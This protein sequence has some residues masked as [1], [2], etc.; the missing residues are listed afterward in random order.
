M[1]IRLTNLKMLCKIN[2][3]IVFHMQLI[4]CHHS[5]SILWFPYPTI[6]TN[7]Q[8]HRP[9][10]QHHRSVYRKGNS[11]E[12]ESHKPTR[13]AINFSITGRDSECK[14]EHQRPTMDRR[15]RNSKSVQCE[16]AICNG[17]NEAEA[18]QPPRVGH[19]TRPGLTCTRVP[20]ND[21]P[22]FYWSLARTPIRAFYFFRF[23]PSPPSP[24]CV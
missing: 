5:I 13:R 24:V 1:P 12:W 19:N 15:E 9:R 17:A 3:R 4:N 23:F 20:D 2:T 6:P 18:E 8:R 14:E 10:K 7:K 11:P 22:T 21:R 16:G